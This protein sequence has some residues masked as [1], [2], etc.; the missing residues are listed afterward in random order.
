L[1]RTEA[2]AAL[3]LA[4][5]FTVNRMTALAAEHRTGFLIYSL[6][7]VFGDLAAADAN[8]GVG[9]ADDV[10]GLHAWYVDAHGIS[11]AAVNV[12]A[13][14]SLRASFQPSPELDPFRGVARDIIVPVASGGDL[15]DEQSV[16]LLSQILSLFHPGF[17][18]DKHRFDRSGPDSFRWSRELF[19]R[20]RD[21]AVLAVPALR[22]GNDRA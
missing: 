3:L 14:R 4:D 5:E 16:D 1:A 7:P 20:S 2:S 18:Q 12:D 22:P 10:A 21:T 13:L 17:P 15:P 9:Y 11:H 6:I 8:S 19:A